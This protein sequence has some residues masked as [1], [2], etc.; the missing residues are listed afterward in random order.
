MVTR[1]RP[2]VRVYFDGTEWSFAAGTSVDT[3]DDLDAAGRTFLV[4][5][6]DGATSQ[7]WREST[8]IS[9]N[10]DAGTK[11]LGGMVLGATATGAGAAKVAVQ[12]MWIK[13]GKSSQIE[14]DIMDTYIRNLIGLAES[15]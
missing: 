9:S 3:G 12:G 7:A 2:Q 4:L 15:S 5:E 8:P 14:R 6:Y 10:V 1:W 13:S 11:A